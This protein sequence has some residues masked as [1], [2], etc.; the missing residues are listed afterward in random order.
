MLIHIAY[1]IRDRVPSN[2]T[3]ELKVSHEFLYI[4]ISWPEIVERFKYIFLSVQVLDSKYV[5]SKMKIK[6]FSWIFTLKVSSDDL[7]SIGFIVRVVEDQKLPNSIKVRWCSIG[8]CKG[9]LLILLEILLQ[10]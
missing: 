10:I 2:I 8:T 1:H 5:V 6:V 3:V 7:L 4:S 9:P